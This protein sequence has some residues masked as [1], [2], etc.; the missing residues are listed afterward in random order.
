MAPTTLNSC[1]ADII[2]PIEK[3]NFHIL[4]KEFGFCDHLCYDNNRTGYE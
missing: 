4:Y 2:L 1:A 3:S